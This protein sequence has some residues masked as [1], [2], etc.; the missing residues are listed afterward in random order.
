MKPV[1][2]IV[3]CES[4]AKNL[5]AEIIRFYDEHKYFRAKFNFSRDRSLD[6]NALWFSMY[7]RISEI[8]G[9]GTAADIAYWRGYCKLTFGVPILQRDSELFCENWQRFVLDN[10]NFDTWESQIELMI[11]RVLFPATQ[12]F[13]VTSLLDKTQGVEYTNELIFYFASLGVSFEDLL[14]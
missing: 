13:P 7:K 5:C 9:L 11:D 8:I 14:K 10:P 3:N 1:T 2:R 6:Q 12:G 4:G